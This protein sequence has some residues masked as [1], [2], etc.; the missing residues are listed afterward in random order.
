MLL[1]LALHLSRPSKRQVLTKTGAALSLSNAYLAL[2]GAVDADI[3][4]DE[5]LAHRTTYRIGGPAAMLAVVHTFSA[6]TRTIEVLTAQDVEWVLM[7]KGS[8]ML[9]SDKGFSGCV[10]VLG[11][12]FSNIIVSP[13]EHTIAAGAAVP[14]AKVVSEAMKASLAG[15]EFACGIPGTLGGAISMNAGMR[16]DWIGSLVESLV[17]WRPGIGLARIAGSDITW[18]YR[19]CSLGGADIVLEVNLLLQEGERAQI[20]AK[21]QS[22]QARRAATQPM[23]KPSCGSV[24]R[25]PSGDK[26]AAQLIQECGL[27]GKVIGGAQ[28][29]DKHANFIVNNGNAT[30]QDVLDLIRLAHDKVEEVSGVSLQPE[31]KFLGFTSTRH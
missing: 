14:L 29:S 7:G 28:I 5:R 1:W 9:V 12:E 24:F 8:N 25:N 11:R 27:K 17:V 2:S 4:C 19:Y 31:V 10:I 23:G 6:L 16:R 15:L 30:A 3:T 21:M 20:A 18:G 13:E 26:G 22:L